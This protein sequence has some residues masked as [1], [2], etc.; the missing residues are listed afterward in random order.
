MSS[1]DWT[2]RRGGGSSAD[3]TDEEF[4]RYVEAHAQTPRHLFTRAHIERLL[5][6]SGFR[7]LTV[8]PAFMALD[9]HT[10]EAMVA[11]ARARA[12]ST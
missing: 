4:L 7:A 12:R 6:L 1:A 11:A 8:H 5:R 3:W 2:D 9:R 10:A